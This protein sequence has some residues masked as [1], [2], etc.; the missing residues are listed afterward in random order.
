MYCHKFVTRTLRLSHALQIFTQ[1]LKKNMV[2]VG[3]NCKHVTVT[4]KTP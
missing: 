1:F 3:H 4:L 2:Y